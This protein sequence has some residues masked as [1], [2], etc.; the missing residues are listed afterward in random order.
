MRNLPADETGFRKVSLRLSMT[1]WG[2]RV[3]GAAEI[4][5]GNNIGD[6][7]AALAALDT[8]GTVGTLSSADP[9]WG[10]YI[11]KALPNW[12]AKYFID[13]LL[14]KRGLLQEAASNP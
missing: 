1:I 9:V 12:A 8:A 5:F 14:E 13:G 7:L 11:P 3:D 4:V 2:V 10:S 6:A